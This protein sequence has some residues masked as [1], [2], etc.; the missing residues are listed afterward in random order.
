MNTL[1]LMMVRVAHVAKKDILRVGE[2]PEVAQTPVWAVL[3]RKISSM[4]HMVREEWAQG[5]NRYLESFNKKIVT[6]DCLEL[7]KVIMQQQ[8]TM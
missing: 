1:I 7:V 3:S 8:R 4:K 2:L 5:A 6:D